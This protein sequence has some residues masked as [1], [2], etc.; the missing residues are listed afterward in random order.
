MGENKTPEALLKK[1][2][3]SKKKKNKT[4]NFQNLKILDRTSSGV[5]IDPIPRGI[6]FS[7]LGI[8]GGINPTKKS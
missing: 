1:A 8:P 3:R 2:S 7:L 4:R 5:E 6:F